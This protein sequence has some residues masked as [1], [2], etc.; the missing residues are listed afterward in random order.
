MHVDHCMTGSSKSFV[1]T[2]TRGFAKDSIRVTLALWD[3]AS[4]IQGSRTR[5]PA[6]LSPMIDRFPCA[7]KGAA[8]MVHS[9]L[10]RTAQKDLLPSEHRMVGLDTMELVTLAQLP[11]TSTAETMPRGLARIR[12]TCRK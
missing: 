11:V 1:R 8:A 2:A 9:L 12:N 3:W 10:G 4:P 7:E 5:E 6:F